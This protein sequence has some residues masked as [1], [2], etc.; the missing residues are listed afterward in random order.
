MISYE[1]L[2]V[3]SVT[4]VLVCFSPG[5][6]ALFVA[7][8][9]TSYGKRHILFAVLGICVANIAFFGLSAL[10]IAGMLATSPVLFQWF[11]W[12]GAAYLVVLG[13]Q[14][15]VSRKS[16][17]LQVAKDNQHAAK[18]MRTFLKGFFVEA[19]NP[20]ALLYFGAL[21]PQ[22]VNPA[23]P[24]ASQLLIYC[25]LTVVFDVMAYSFYSVMGLGIA[26]ASKQKFY[27]V[28]NRLA[29]V[30]FILAGVRLAIVE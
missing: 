11:R 24:L 12:I 5:P 23:Q 9:A 16:Q 6:A 14:L 13:L 2:I 30:A 27:L 19:S 3:F 18:R 17:P 4:T 28:I 20:K 1:A 7:S 8:T 22:F 10:G 15:L 25:L 29:G 21:L 26:K